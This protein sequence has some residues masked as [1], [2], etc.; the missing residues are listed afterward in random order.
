MLSWPTY[1]WMA[2]ELSLIW[3]V[4]VWFRYPIGPKKMSKAR[5]SIR[6]QCLLLQIS[7]RI[8]MTARMTA[9]QAYSWFLGQ[10]LKNMR[11]Q[12]VKQPKCIKLA[13]KKSNQM[14]SLQF[15]RILPHTNHFIIS[16]HL[17]HWN[18]V[19]FAVSGVCLTLQEIFIFL[20]IFETKH[21]MM[22]LNGI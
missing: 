17:Y 7:L 21:Q 1:I 3:R 22:I 6:G 11:N 15:I 5:V 16:N 12:A 4:T 9:F 14:L 18:C 19:P 2:N 13:P 8:R 10:N 20:K